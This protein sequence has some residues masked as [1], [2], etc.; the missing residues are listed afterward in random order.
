VYSVN[1]L[2]LAVR[3]GATPPDRRAV[4][5][6]REIGKPEPLLA[7]LLIGNSAAD[8]AGSLGLTMLLAMAGLREWAVIA[9]NAALLTP[10][11]FI[12]GETIPKD[13]FRAEADRMML[14]FALPITL[15]RLALTATLLL[16][17]VTLVT[18]LMQRLIGGER[19]ESIAHRQRVGALL[20]EGASGGA[21]SVEQT[22]LIDRALFVGEAS[23]TDVMRPWRK[24]SR[25]GADWKGDRI[26]KV[27]LRASR[28]SQGRMPVVDRRGGVVGLVRTIEAALAGDDISAASLATTAM[29]IEASASVQ[30]ALR[31]LAEQDV[32]WAVVVAGGEPV[33]LVSYDDLLGPLLG[34][35]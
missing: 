2:R 27:A 13:Y 8:Y 14:R 11:L 1:R 17:V 33:G 9:I 10:A 35:G 21:L 7:A 15:L 34:V 30:H 3:A 20:K 4:R 22:S 26:R 28:T 25:L 32:S 12:L 18:R 19:L 16:P 24:V 5:L 29:T 23:I 6:E 31:L